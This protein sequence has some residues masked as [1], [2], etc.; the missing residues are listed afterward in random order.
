MPASQFLLSGLSIVLIDLLLAGDNALVI[1]MAVR[2]LSGRDRRV[3]IIC[4][5]VLAVVL[6]VALTAVA[7]TL[8]GTKYVELAGGVF[9]LWIALKVL[10]DADD[11]PDAAPAPRRLVQTI[12]F[13]VLADLTMSV[14][15]IL[16]IA[17]AAHGHYGLIAFG[18][19]LSIPFV[20]FSSNLLADVMDRFPILVYLGVAILGKVGGDMVL[21]DRFVL[22]TAHP[23]DAIRYLI[24]AVL[25][26]AI[27][28]AGR[29]ITAGRRKQA[30][31]PA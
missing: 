8:L 10:V 24:D 22:Q 18:L 20:I 14:D 27:L 6:R 21:E 5:A 11:P 15:N 29:R 25:I 28:V 26:A 1:A 31:S 7:S 19:A 3:G 9:V 4:G 30:E 23:T 2:S 12:W 13:I 16:A 17:G